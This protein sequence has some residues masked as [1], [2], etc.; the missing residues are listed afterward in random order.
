MGLPGITREKMA[1]VDRIMV[2]DFKIPV[3]LMME[4]AGLNLAKLALNLSKNKYSNYII[5]A[6]TGNNAGGGIVAARR[7]ASWGLNTQVFFPRGMDKLKEV[8][9]NQ[10]TRA[11]FLEIEIANGLPYNFLNFE[12][13]TLFI[14]AYLGYGFN[15]RPDEI[16]TKVFNFYSHLHNLISLDIPSGLDATTGENFSGINP[17]ATL[18]LAYVKQGLLITEKE[19]VGDLYIADIGIPINIYYKIFRN[20][21][22]PNF[23]KTSLQNL[24]FAFKRNPIHEV[25]V[26]KDKIREKSYWKV[27]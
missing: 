15:P 1:E 7:L 10:L 17:V 5:I 19:N 12:N 26:Y 24:Y 8:P 11:K 25:K 14:D 22:S 23:K 9:K 13:D 16:S 6:G 27:D 18:T 20:L 2:E 3:E 21:W 4:L